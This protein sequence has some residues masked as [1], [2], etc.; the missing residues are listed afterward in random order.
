MDSIDY[1][2]DIGKTGGAVAMCTVADALKTEGRTEGRIEGRQEGRIEG[3]V[4]ILITAKF[5]EDKIADMVMEQ[6]NLP[7]GEVEKIIRYVKENSNK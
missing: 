5:N 1:L 4:E 2:D 3:A 6:F 7:R